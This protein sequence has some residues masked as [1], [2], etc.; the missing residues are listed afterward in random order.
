MVFTPEA[1]R[2]LAQLYS[3]LGDDV[4]GRIADVLDVLV[5]DGCLHAGE[6]GYRFPF[7]LLRDW[8]SNRFRDRHT[9]LG[10]RLSDEG[11]GGLQ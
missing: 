11:K 10:S 2:Y 1:R 7:R 6:N 4:H 9:P 3:P 5:H 8:W